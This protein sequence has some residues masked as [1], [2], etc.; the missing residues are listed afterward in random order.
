MRILVLED[1]ARLAVRELDATLS[2]ASMDE[3]RDALAPQLIAWQ[4]IN[5]L[6]DALATDRPY[7]EGDMSRLCI[8]EPIF[9]THNPPDPD[10]CLYQYTKAMT[11]PKIRAIRSLKFRALKQMNDPQEAL[12]TIAFQTGLIGPV[13]SSLVLTQED[14]S[15]FRQ[16]TGLSRSTPPAAMSRLARIAWIR[17][18][19]YPMSTLISRRRLFLAD[20]QPTAGMPIP[21]CG[22]NMAD[23]NP[24][25]MPGPRPR[26]PDRCS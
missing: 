5:G 7:P 1:R 15:A 13:G 6:R 20:L 21:G 4:E 22:P 25:S 14:A 16:E 3:Y 2:G 24:R 11:L 12:F 17:S 18:P 19:T 9:G 8:D 23:A 10:K 26:P